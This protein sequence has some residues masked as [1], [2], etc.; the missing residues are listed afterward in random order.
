MKNLKVSVKLLIGFGISA[1][2]ILVVGLVSIL[3]LNNLNKDYVDVIEKYGAPLAD[4]GQILATIHSLRAE[5]R[6]CIIF[7]GNKDRVRESKS[8]MDVLFKKFEDVSMSYGKVITRTDA[9][10]LF[11]EA[12]DKY[13]KVYK[14][15]ARKIA[16]DA[17]RGASTADL[18]S[19]MVN[20]TSPAS[21]LIG[22][23]MKRC[24]DIEQDMLH[25]EEM[26]GSA[27]S[28]LIIVIVIVLMLLC[29]ALSSVLG[30]Y[31]SNMISKPLNDT[32]KM[33]KEMGKGHLKM[34]L[35]L[36]RDDEIGV[37][38]KTMDKFAS[39]LQNELLANLKMIAVG[40]LSSPVTQMDCE[41]EIGGTL[42][43][44]VITLKTTVDV[45]KKIS[46]GDL[47]AKIESKGDKDEISDALNRT[48][49]T[50]H[51]LIVDDGGMVLNAAANRD[52]SQRLTQEYT[53]EFAKMK[54]DINTVMQ[55][56]DD[57]ITQVG[58]IV[59]QV[60]DVSMEISSG[61][62]DLAEGSSEQASSLE[63]VS[64]SLEEISSMT[65][66]N[67]DNSNQAKILAAEA[68]VAANDGDAT[69]RRMAAAINQIKLMSDNT[70]KIIKTIDDIAFQTN[71]LALNAAVEAARAG[72]AG[73]GFA[74]VAEEVRNLAM[75]SAEAASN[76]AKMIEESVKNADGGVKIT[77]E[78]AKSLGHIVDRTSKVNNL[79]DEI[80]VASG[81]QSQGIEQVNIAVA[82]MNDV[83]QR[84][85][86][87]S[88]E[89]AGAS[90]ELS[91]Q[92]S[93]LAGMV[94][95]FKLSSGGGPQSAHHAVGAVPQLPAYQ[96][97]GSRGGGLPSLA[98]PKQAAAI[99]NMRAGGSPSSTPPAAELPSP[100]P[101]NVGV[102]AEHRNGGRRGLPSLPPPGVKSARAIKPEEIIPLDDDDLNLF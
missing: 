53:G 7:T 56:L 49:D 39:D 94:R 23:N 83:T 85:A 59:T 27:L 31:I 96:G 41:D 40:D 12:L 48:I 101:A 89:S 38:A 100:A 58:K 90:Q 82:Q 81:E 46:I 20:V 37:M 66:Q 63:E 79:I 44:M 87:S 4:A 9:K 77:E 6:T 71:L 70:V 32:V 22:K 14:P 74:V 67:A 92:A 29:L 54:S 43:K 80:A 30:I 1:V 91:I 52:L 34:R 62:Q 18:V 76:T 72:E 60:S 61:A 68:R 65:K 42:E 64:A 36:N 8:E 73:K 28:N 51:R 84:N 45:I 15:G 19:E 93:E 95:S 50:L 21:D 69:V 99:P 55:S 102:E 57:A 5:T 75:L 13:E 47:S 35:N 25:D 78:V 17:E 24:M 3:S 98:P 26:R 97:G 33:I 10:E 11:D 88:E 2:F 16:E 86:A